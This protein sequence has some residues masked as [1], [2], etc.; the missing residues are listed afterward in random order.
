MDF[1]LLS[2]RLHFHLKYFQEM[3]KRPVPNYAE[4]ATNP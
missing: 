4:L 1:S 2:V 3:D